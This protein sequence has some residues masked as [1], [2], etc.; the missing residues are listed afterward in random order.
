MAETAQTIGARAQQAM[1][2]GRLDEALADLSQLKILIPHDAT[3]WL[4]TAY[5]LRAKNQL[6]ESRKQFETAAMMAPNDANIRFEFA[7]FLDQTGD[8]LGSIEQY[9]HVL[10]IAP[11]HLDTLIDRNLVLAK[12]GKRADAM[13]ALQDIA[14]Q[15]PDMLRVWTN[16]AVLLREDFRFD[17]AEKAAKHVL[18]RDSNNGRAA[19]ILAQCAFDKGE[20]ASNLFVK[21]RGLTPDNLDLLTG[22]AG[23]LVQ[24]DLPEK[25]IALLEGQISEDPL[26]ASGHQMLADIRWQM[27]G[28]KDF[29]QS[30]LPVLKD[31]P[32]AV[33]LWSNYIVAVSRAIGH[34]KA[35]TLID[36]ARSHNPDEMAFDILAANSY[37]ELENFDQAADLFD[38][39]DYTTDA[40]TQLSYVR[41]LIKSGQYEQAAKWGL[42]LVDKGWGADAWPFISIA[43]RKMND[44]RWGWLEGDHEFAR[45]FDIDEMQDEIATLAVRLREMHKYE[46]HPFAQ[47]MRGGTQTDG[48]LFSKQIP[49]IQSLVGHLRRT[50]ET[51]VSELP[52]KDE[53]HPLLRM[54]RE[55][56][57]FT[58][59]WSVRLTNAGFHVNHIHNQGNISSAFYVTVP[60]DIGNGND[61]NVDGWLAVGEPAT[62]LKTGLKPIHL[63]EPKPGRLVLFPSTMWHGTRPFGEGERLSCAFDIG[64]FDT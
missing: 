50:V 15:T 51:Y 9:D 44:S 2:D 47:S 27:A 29:I 25:A 5:A 3:I 48:A 26:W 57:R 6:D 46:V 10:R 24:E 32:Q 30:Y 64:L 59:S 35:V 28:D 55:S 62:E 37:S 58:G 13:K 42:D 54:N 23:A 45:Q 60:E 4:M 38:K 19:H 8:L 52:A 49:E 17:E 53:T 31:N 63:F 43:W 11:G 61:D 41:F 40:A 14:K 36:E 39:F 20:R 12:T 1:Q 7:K 16:L 33:D 22:E 34:E 21:A 56:F 18:Q